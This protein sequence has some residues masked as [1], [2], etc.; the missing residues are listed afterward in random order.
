MDYVSN[1]VKNSEKNLHDPCA[2][3]KE[4]KKNKKKQEIEKEKEGKVNERK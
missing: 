2:L 1:W 4:G 3:N